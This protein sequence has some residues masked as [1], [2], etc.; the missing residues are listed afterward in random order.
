MQGGALQWILVG[1]LH[2]F[3]SSVLPGS[4]YLCY[5]C[6]AWCG[7][8]GGRPD[9]VIVPKSEKTEVQRGTVILAYA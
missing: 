6:R 9:D 8:E 4:R 2:P 5:F 7:E 3:M 1:S